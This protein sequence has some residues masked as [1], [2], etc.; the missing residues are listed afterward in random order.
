MG[1]SIITCTHMNRYM[2]NIFNNYARQ[3][4]NHKELIL[5]LNHCALNLGDWVEKSK[6]YPDVRIYTLPEGTPVGTC[7]NF[8]VQQSRCEYIANFDHDDYYGKKYLDDYMEVA[9]G[10][11]AGLFGKKSHYIYLEENGLLAL[12]HPNQEN[13][14][15]DYVDGPTMFFR[16]SITNQVRFIDSNTSDCDFSWSCKAHGIKIYSVNRFHFA[17]IRKPNV[18]L[19]T[20]KIPNDELVATYCQPIGN[21]S[22]FKPHIDCAGE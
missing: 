3:S 11:D 6:P 17:Y 9:P 8:A 12:M 21:V 16:K 20:W 5:V 10:S 2:D 1:V 18:N 13:M 4:Y 22:D 19:H 7:M 14:Y 15:V